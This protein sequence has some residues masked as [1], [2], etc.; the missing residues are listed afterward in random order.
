MAV[1]GRVFK[2]QGKAVPQ[3]NEAASRCV[4]PPAHPQPGPLN[5]TQSRDPDCKERTLVHPF[6][7]GPNG[8]STVSRR[9]SNTAGRFANRAAIRSSTASF[10]KR[11]KARNVPAA[12]RERIE[13][14]SHAGLLPG[15]INENGQIVELLSPF[16]AIA[17]REAAAP[18]AA[19]LLGGG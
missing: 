6:L 15:L 4:S 3:G 17:R 7:D 2:R 13:Q 5:A 16:A 14:S 11:E 1:F 10:S 19:F 9:Q 8:S 12:H 18:G